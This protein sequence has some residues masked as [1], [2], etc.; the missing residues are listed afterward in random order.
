MIG[1]YMTRLVM[2]VR[3]LYI[4]HRARVYNNTHNNKWDFK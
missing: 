2:Y 3:G 1:C 4:L